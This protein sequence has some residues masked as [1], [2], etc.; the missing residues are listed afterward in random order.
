MR[1][2]GTSSRCAPVFALG[3]RLLRGT[4]SGEKS[5]WNRPCSGTVDKRARLRTFSVNSCGL[6][7]LASTSIAPAR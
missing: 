5:A 7:G 4:T 2:M 3:A 6:T 1:S